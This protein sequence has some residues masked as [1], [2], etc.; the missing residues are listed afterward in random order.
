[1]TPAHRRAGIPLSVAAALRRLR[2]H[3][4]VLSYAARVGFCVGF[5]SLLPVLTDWSPKAAQLFQLPLFAPVFVAVALGPSHVGVV[6]DLG[7]SILTG[8][9]LGACLTCAVVV[10]AH[11]AHGSQ[12]STTY[13]VLVVLCLTVLYPAHS[14]LAAKMAANCVIITVFTAPTTDLR[15]LALFPWHLV[16]SV[17]AGL[18]PCLLF[19][20]LLPWPGAR[21]C[22][23]ADKLVHS[24]SSSTSEL[25][26]LLCRMLGDSKADR[27]A[28]RAA[29][30]RATALRASAAAAMT[31]LQ[32]LL[33][34]CDWEAYVGMAPRVHFM[35]A[36]NQRL[37]FL[38]EVLLHVDG[39]HMTSTSLKV[40]EA[41]HAQAAQR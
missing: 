29:Q 4:A 40:V 35:H 11:A 5:A 1:M 14:P 12:D 20:V 16:L 23:A 15:S 26:L 37:A 8:W 3:G 18:V 31:E 19:N 25:V 33:G 17:V 6:L 32:A 41:Q 27:A 21:A 13:V 30:A 38:R 39:L 9:L 10:A 7:S 24:I 34:P 28:G 22:L 2:P 36:L